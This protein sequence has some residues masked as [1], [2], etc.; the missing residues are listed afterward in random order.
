MDERRIC[1]KC[2]IKDM[3]DGEE[4]FRNLYEYI[5]NLDEEMK[6]SEELY[7][8]R[9]SCCKECDSLLSGMCRHC[10]CYVEMRAVVKKNY[11]PVKKW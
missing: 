6:A 3:A 5:E 7:Q 8:E 10:G 2:L 11:C 1:K 9:L 4:M